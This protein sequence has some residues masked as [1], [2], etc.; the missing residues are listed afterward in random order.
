MYYIIY[1]VTNKLDGKIYIGSHKTKKLDDG[2][3]GS[4]KYL[5]RAQEK[6]GIENFT[7][8]ILFVFDTPELMYAKEAELVNEDFLVNENTYNLKKGGFG[9]WDYI[10]NDEQLRKIK[11]KKARANTD[12][13][14]EEKYGPEWRTTLAKMGSAGR[15][16]ESIKK[17]KQTLIEKYGSPGTKPFL[18]KCHSEDSKQLIGIKNSVHQSGQGNSQF[19]TR[20]IHNLELKI[21]KKIS[22]D[23]PLPAGWILG[24]K[25][26]F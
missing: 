3:M 8:E 24:R 1:K 13:I 15:T 14:L 25:I 23:E 7:K 18:G 19:G 6:Y 17:R 12:K 10:N 5:R 16:I 26:K 21:S 9:G 4:G 22:K 11:N 20:W 2:Y